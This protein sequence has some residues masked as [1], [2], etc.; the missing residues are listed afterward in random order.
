MY[1][2]TGIYLTLTI[3]IWNKFILNQFNQN[4]IENLHTHEVR[5]ALLLI[6]IFL[7]L[8]FQ[9]HSCIEEM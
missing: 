8:F 2:S 5:I 7:S 3:Q 6:L 4:L 9:V 1:L